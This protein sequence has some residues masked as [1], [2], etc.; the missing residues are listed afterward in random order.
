M[1]ISKAFQGRLKLPAIAAPMF[2]ASGPELV[3]EVCRS[4]VIGTGRQI[5]AARM[6]GAD[7]AY[8]GKRRWWMKAIRAC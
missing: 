1:A 4:G 3:V 6:M 5:A 2:L 8:L 7:L